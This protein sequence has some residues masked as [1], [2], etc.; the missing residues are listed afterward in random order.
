MLCLRKILLIF[1][2]VLGTFENTV[3]H[4]FKTPH[5]LVAYVL[6]HCGSTFS[7]PKKEGSFIKRGFEGIE[8]RDPFEMIGF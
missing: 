2:I 5:F 1:E 3:F 7:T 6:F 8:T 4:Q